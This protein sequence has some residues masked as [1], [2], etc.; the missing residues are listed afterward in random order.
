MHTSLGINDFSWVDRLC[1]EEGI[2]EIAIQDYQNTI[3]EMQHDL[4]IYRKNLEDEKA[5]ICARNLKNF[6]CSREDNAGKKSLIDFLVRNNVL[7]KY[8]FPVDT[9][10]L[11][12]DMST[13]GTDKSL[14]LARDLQLAIA[15][16]A[17]D[18]QVIADGKMYTSRYI[19]KTPGKASTL[20]WEIGYYCPKCPVCG[21]ANFT[22][23]P[24]ME[25][26]HECVVCHTTIPLA[27]WHRTIE[28]RLGFAAEP[29]PK[30]VP[31]HRPE[32]D[33]KS[34]DYYIGDPHKNTILKQ[35]FQVRG[36]FVSLE[37][38]SNDS[39]VVVGT[40]LISSVQYADMRSHNP[41]V[42]SRHTITVAGSPAV[43]NRLQLDTIFP[44]ILKQM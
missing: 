15:E 22:K 17:P 31:M 1:G 23:D 5:G 13:L 3:A 35:T 21:Q 27:Q 29:K 4:E 44:T 38:T 10:E 34:D 26:G 7:P 43:V 32:H 25:N 12:T 28:P 11:Y 36:K 14:Q 24:Y 20:S 42:Q 39:L 19:R 30:S 6:R 40:P 37:S 16:Y 9:V 2:L 8:G 41:K 33:H 18:S